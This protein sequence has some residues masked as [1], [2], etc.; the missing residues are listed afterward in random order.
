MTTKSFYSHY[1]A[2]FHVQKTR[3]M[4]RSVSKKRHIHDITSIDSPHSSTHGKRHAHKSSSFPSAYRL[5]VTTTRGVYAWDVNGVIE[6]FHSGSEG[7]VAARKLSGPGEMLAVADSQ[8]V[9][10]HD[11]NKGM[12]KSYRL[13]GSEVCPSICIHN[14]ARLTTFTYP[15][16]SPLTEI[17]RRLVPESI[18]YNFVTQLCAVFLLEVFQNPGPCRQPSISTV[19]LRL[20][21]YGA[22]PLVCIIN[23]TNNLPSKP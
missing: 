22:S 11:I 14:P 9:V 21:L 16:T 15:G 7:I 18:L 8:V 6:L 13:K 2:S 1:F 10:L 4:S 3:A 19:R 12:Q 17:C 5:I 23:T 20:V